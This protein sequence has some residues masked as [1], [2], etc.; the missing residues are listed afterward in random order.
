MFRF[1][2]QSERPYCTLQALIEEYQER[3]II[4]MLDFFTEKVYSPKSTLKFPLFLPPSVSL[5]P[6]PSLCLS[7]CVS[8]PSIS[9]PLPPSLSLFL[10]LHLSLSLLPSLSLRLPLPPF[11]SLAHHPPSLSLS[12]SLNPPSLSFS[13]LSVSLSLLHQHNHKH[14]I[15]HIHETG[16]YI[17]GLRV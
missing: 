5:P 1:V 8:P 4:I 14:V 7:I 12:L 6:C 11:L 2:N 3:H 13:L 16:T 17:Q 9:L 15:I 10:S